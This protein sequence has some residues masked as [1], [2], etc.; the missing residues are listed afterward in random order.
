VLLEQ[1]LGEQRQTWRSIA[2]TGL[3]AAV[4][5]SPGMTAPQPDSLRQNVD[6]GS[7]ATPP[8]GGERDVDALEADVALQA[9]SQEDTEE[10]TLRE[11]RTT[12]R[13][14][15]GRAPALGATSHTNGMNEI[16][17]VMYFLL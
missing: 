10:A 15:A 2:S 7:A 9:T 5:L 14:A 4:Q 1:A 17:R 12:P 16:T 6:V 13:V 3:R 11:Q 8:P